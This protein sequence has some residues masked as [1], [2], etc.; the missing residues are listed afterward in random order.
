MIFPAI[1]IGNL[2]WSKNATRCH[3]FGFNGKEKTDEWQGAGMNYDYGF[4]IHDPRLGRFLS[5]DPLTQDFP[6]YSPYQ[7]AGNKPVWCRDI[8]GLEDG[9]ST[10]MMVNNWERQDK[11]YA[12]GEI[13]WDEYV[14]SRTRSQMAYGIGGVAGLTAASLFYGIEAALPMIQGMTATGIIW[15]SNPANQHIIVGVGG[16]TA[17]I[18]DP[19]PT[20]DYPG[21]LDDIARGV[22]LLF[23]NSN[24]EKFIL[25]SSKF[26]YFFGKVQSS[27]HNTERS[28]QNAKDLATLGIKDD[29][30]GRD[31]LAQI[32]EQGI[33]GQFVKEVKSEYGTTVFRKVEIQNGDNKGAINI[34][35]F[36]PG[37]NMSSTPEI[38]TIV[39]QI[40]N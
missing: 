20:S 38:S 29:K 6:W 40:Y 33:E 1:H 28:L 23:K 19:N 25:N 35:Y 9:V 22:R 2:V 30:A 21:G 24:A 10:T 15:M 17:S 13:T 36:Y 26:D 37:G 16:L 11:K 32:I 14:T 7:Y 8:D 39:P 18:I 12:N 3:R 4:R 31:K 5:V 27:K 34:G